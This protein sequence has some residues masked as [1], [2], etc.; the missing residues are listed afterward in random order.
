M[1]TQQLLRRFG[2][3]FWMGV[4]VLLFAG[5]ATQKTVPPLFTAMPQK[6][7][8][9]QPRFLDVPTPP[10]TKPFQIVIKIPKKDSAVAPE[11]SIMR[12]GAIIK[13]GSS[14]V[15][16]VPKDFAANLAKSN[17]SD[18]P[19]SRG[20]A[21]PT[22]GNPT[23]FKT[24]EYFNVLEQYIER[25]LI[26][27]G[28]Q[29]K[30]RSKFEAKLRDLRDS[31]KAV[32]DNS[33]AIA[34]ADLK[35]DLE[36]GKVSRDEFAEK[37]KQLQN[38]LDPTGGAGEKGRQEMADISEV[39]RAA[40]A[41]DIMA[42]YVLQVNHLGIDDFKGTP[43]QLH[44]RTEVQAVRNQ[45]PG[46]LID[47]ESNALRDNG[48]AIAL[49]DLKKDL[50]NGKV[51]RDEFAEKA[52]QLQDKLDPTGGVGLRHSLPA[53]I[54]RP[55]AQAIFNAKL[56]EVKTGSIDW[57]GEF[58]VESLTVLEDG[59]TITI[60]GRRNTSNGK[61]IVGAISEYNT[62]VRAAYQAA[63]NAKQ[64][65]DEKY[66]GVM[67]P[68]TYEGDAQIGAEIQ[69]KRKS[70]VEEAEKKFAQRAAEYRAT[71]E[72]KPPEAT[73]DW[74]Y[75]YDVDRPTVDPD[76]LQT[77]TEEERQRRR[78]HDKALGLKVTRDLLQTIKMAKEEGAK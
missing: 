21:S 60:E 32:R 6:D 25:G 63:V 65:L 70:E 17:Q 22:S 44:K 26:A 66:R 41:G 23:D 78:I 5:C 74:T 71:I 53:T 47:E 30:D 38:K 29:A 10:E 18:T 69:N 67:Q 42:D 14:V 39:I 46:L 4:V 77:K 2:A 61:A 24:D 76:I 36:N 55:W 34:L 73:M 64:Q 27:V 45:N 58:S 8:P 48:Y 50:E 35:K 20:D 11:N 56:I 7:A 72:R 68:V 33:Y 54:P 1:K 9:S 16:S 13:P 40:Q 12:Q 31:S 43:I 51:S 59:I 57:I 62:L 3:F 52:K 75:K 19:S 49:A 28:F 37:A 15:I